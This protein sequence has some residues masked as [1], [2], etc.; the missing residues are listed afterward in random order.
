MNE[1]GELTLLEDNA[2][3]LSTIYDYSYYIFQDQTF[4]DMKSL[5]LDIKLE[6]IDNY[7]LPF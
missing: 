7:K 4:K 2:I 5:G 1:P 6:L 3:S